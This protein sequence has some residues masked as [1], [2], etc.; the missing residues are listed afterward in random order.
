M[1]LTDTASKPFFA[2]RWSAVSKILSFVPFILLSIVVNARLLIK[3][4]N[5]RSL[6]NGEKLIF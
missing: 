1:S 2:N 6:G 4:V 5:E 3:L